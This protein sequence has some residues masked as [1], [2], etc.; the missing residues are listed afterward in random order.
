M[1]KPTLLKSLFYIPMLLILLINISCKNSTFQEPKDENESK[2]TIEIEDTDEDDLDV[3]ESQDLLDLESEYSDMLSQISSLK[4]S[5]PKTY[6]FIVSWLKTAYK[7]PDWTGYYSEE[8]K[9]SAK[10]NGIDCSG[11]SRVMLN[12]IFDKEVAGGSQRLLD[13]YCNRVE[14]VSLSMGDLVFFRAPYATTDKIVHVGVYLQDNYFVHATSTKSAAEGL[15][16]SV[17]SLEEENWA[18]EFVTGGKLKD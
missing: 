17:N 4:T 2:E 12:Q 8:W 11:F 14:K 7:T 10:Q 6:W 13:H 3:D 16:L 1:K 5:E 15:G 18:K 9:K